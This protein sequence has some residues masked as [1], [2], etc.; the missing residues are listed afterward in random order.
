MLKALTIAA[1][2]RAREYLAH[3]QVTR[4]IVQGNNDAD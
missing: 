2:Q 1:M 4:S 3:M